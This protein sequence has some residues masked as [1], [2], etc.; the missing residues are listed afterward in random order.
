[1][2]N[3]AMAECTEKDDSVDKEKAGSHRKPIYSFLLL[4]Q[5]LLYFKYEAHPYRLCIYLSY[6]KVFFSLVADY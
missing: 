3:P 4:L 2:K 5:E 6:F 1:M